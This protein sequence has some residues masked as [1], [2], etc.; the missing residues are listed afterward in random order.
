MA[1]IDTNIKKGQYLKKTGAD[2]YVH[3]HFD[4]DDSIVYLS[5]NLN[6]IQGGGEGNSS[7]YA[8]GTTL[9]ETLSAL[10]TLASKGGQASTDLATLKQKVNNLETKHTS[11][12]SAVNTSIATTKNDLL[13]TTSDAAGASTINGANKAAQNAQN[14]ANSAYKLASGLSKA[15]VFGN[16]SAV[17]HGRVGG[18]V[19]SDG[20]TAGTVIDKDFKVGD[21]VYVRDTR[22]N[23]FWISEKR[24]LVTD[25]TGLPISS[26]DDIKNATDGAEINVKWIIGREYYYVTLTAVETKA[27]LDGYYDKNY[28][29]N[30]FYDKPTTDGKYVPYSG[31]TGNVN[32]GEHVL[33]V[34]NTERANQK[35]TSIAGGRIALVGLATVEN[36][37]EI[38]DVGRKVELNPTGIAFADENKVYPY[39]RGASSPLATEEFVTGQKYQTADEVGALINAGTVKLKGDVTGNGKV[40][41]SE[42]NTN[43]S[44]TGIVPGT[45]SALT[46]DAKGRATEGWQWLVFASTINDDE[47]LNN[48]AVG[49]VAII[50]AQ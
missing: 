40:N 24:K 22:I 45:Y 30:N 39:P 16:A 42:I 15:Y 26:I 27:N 21:S 32:I 5:D 11:D 7:H 3:Y 23:D 31:A 14:K 33:I 37:G 46:V 48:L 44:T 19:D 35:F 38:T 25:D 10:Y 6:R 50:D 29:D 36:G 20:A 49:G 4:T 34:G 2:S 47:I 43:L 9:H 8:K 13:G 12:I 17:Y 1:N 28:I 41:G 18:T